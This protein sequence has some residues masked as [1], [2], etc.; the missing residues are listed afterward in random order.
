M[1]SS[2]AW[3]ASKLLIRLVQTAIDPFTNRIVYQVTKISPA[4]VANDLLSTNKPISSPSPLERFR[5]IFEFVNTFPVDFNWFIE[6][7]RSWQNLLRGPWELMSLFVNCRPL[8]TLA[9][10]ILVTRHTMRLVKGSMAVW[11]SLVR[12][13]EADRARDKSI[14]SERSV[15]GIANRVNGHGTPTSLLWISGGIEVGGNFPV[16][17][18]ASS[19]VL[20]RN[21]CSALSFS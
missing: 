20:Y 8:A 14:A 13:S 18:F 4:R 9:R 11:M 16:E 12:N 5:F 1:L 21:H 3:S 17:L 7:M 6:T 19:D 2:L 15:G 10:L